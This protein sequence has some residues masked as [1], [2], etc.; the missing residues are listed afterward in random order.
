MEESKAVNAARDVW[1]QTVTHAQR[2][3]PEVPS[4]AVQVKRLLLK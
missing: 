3:L 1:A 2:K 4:G